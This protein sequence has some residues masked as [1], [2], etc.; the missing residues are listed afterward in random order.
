MLGDAV[1]LRGGGSDGNAAGNSVVARWDSG[2]RDSA[3]HENVITHPVLPTAK[4]AWSSE[5]PP[6]PGPHRVYCMVAF[7][8]PHPHH[9]DHKEQ[10]KLFADNSVKKGSIGVER[11]V[12]FCHFLVCVL[13]RA[14]VP[15]AINVCCLFVLSNDTISGSVCPDL[16]SCL[17][18][19]RL[20]RA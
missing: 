5:N 10:V 16:A 11:C 15:L 9:G 6:Y 7:V 1:E 17:L 14:A 8:W 3:G 12:I 18:H 20:N 4:G 19:V 13:T 2:R